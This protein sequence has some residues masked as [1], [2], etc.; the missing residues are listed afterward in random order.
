MAE[1]ERL[2][3][4][5]RVRKLATLGVVGFAVLAIFATAYGLHA[6]ASL[7]GRYAERAR[8]LAA[9]V[10]VLEK[11][12]RSDAALLR[13]AFDDGELLALIR[14]QAG[15]WSARA[16]RCAEIRGELALLVPETTAQSAR[17]MELD[18][19]VKAMERASSELGASASEGD[20]VAARET[21]RLIADEPDEP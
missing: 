13:K 9:D 6:R 12:A 18:E 21:L 3:W 5:L 1:S 11:G 17:Q 7:R 10:A 15:A 16:S 4:R 8:A 2:V 19:V 14:E 20:P